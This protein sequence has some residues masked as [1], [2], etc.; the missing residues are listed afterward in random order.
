MYETCRSFPAESLWSVCAVHT[1]GVEADPRDVTYAQIELQ[2]MKKTQ[3][4]DWKLFHTGASIT[5][6]KPSNN[7]PKIYLLASYTP[8]GL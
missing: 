2:K 4:K 7:L 3:E 5:V 8:D 6:N 1:H